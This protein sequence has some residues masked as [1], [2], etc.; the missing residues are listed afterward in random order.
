MREWRMDGIMELVL[1]KEKELRE[2]T[3]TFDEVYIIS[4]RGCIRSVLVMRL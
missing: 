2:K 3:C 4:Q 1:W